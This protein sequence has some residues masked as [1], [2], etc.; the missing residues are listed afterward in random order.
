MGLNVSQIDISL[1]GG[2]SAFQVS[3]FEAGNL[4]DSCNLSGGTCTLSVGATIPANTQVYIHILG[5][6]NAVLSIV[7]ILQ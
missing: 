6:T 4:I 1:P 5:P 3:L 7:T 2:S